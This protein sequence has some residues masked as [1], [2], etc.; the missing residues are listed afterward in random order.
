MMLQYYCILDTDICSTWVNNS[1]FL[2][3]HHNLLSCPT[4]R[5]TGDPKSQY[6]LSDHQKFR[7]TNIVLIGTLDL[8]LE[9][10]E[11]AC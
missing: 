11:L 4:K 5:E 6:L 1:L 2:I 3:P 9:I 7:G 10:Q 8:G